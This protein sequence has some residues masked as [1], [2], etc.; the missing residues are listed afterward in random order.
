M[1][2]LP[3]AHFSTGYQVPLQ[4]GKWNRGEKGGHNN[5]IPSALTLLARM[6]K[7]AAD[8]AGKRG[9]SGAAL[10]RG[11]ELELSVEGLAGGGSRGAGAGI[12]RVDG[13]VVFVE[14][15]LPGSVVRARVTEVCSCMSPAHAT[16]R[17]A[18]TRAPPR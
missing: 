9:R 8:A 7:G 6:E 17:R 1:R 13:F 11:Q 15:G 12:A 16:P 5:K 10:K 4:K 14:G 3:L 18:H 2:R